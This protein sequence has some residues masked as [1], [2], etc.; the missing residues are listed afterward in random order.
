MNRNKMK[1]DLFSQSRG[2]TL[3][4][5]LTAFVLAIFFAATPALAE[6]PEGED[7]KTIYFIGVILSKQA[8]FSTLSPEEVTLV[9]QG[10]QDS[11]S[12]V[13]TGLDPAEYGAKVQSL[14]ESRMTMLMDKEK[15]EGIKYADTMGKKEGAEKTPS[16]LILISEEE[17]SGVSPSST[18]TVK[19]H[20]H[21]TLRD[22]T[23]FDS[24]LERG[25]PVEFALN[26]VIP[27]WTEGVAKMKAGGKATLVCPPEIA[28]GD[29]GAPPMIP[30][31]ATLTFVVDLIEVKPTP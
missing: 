28:Y 19:V 11:L 26:R 18:D 20:Y 13:D 2:R 9:A 27:C 1:V 15:S 23:V 17:G 7:E 16:G 14:T 10:I 8:P 24:S 31:G 30:G 6:V 22:G 25:E 21:G 4:V 5:L 29:R 3:F 12:G